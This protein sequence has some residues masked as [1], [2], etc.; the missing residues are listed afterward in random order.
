MIDVKLGGAEDETGDGG[1]VAII[2]AGLS[3]LVSTARPG[4]KEGGGPCCD[5]VVG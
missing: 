3:R 5:G 2:S 1:E 4:G